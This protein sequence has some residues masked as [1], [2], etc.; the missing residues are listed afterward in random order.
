MVGGSA[1]K[2]GDADL[3]RAALPTGAGGGAL[4]LHGGVEAGLIEVNA[5]IARG[6]D[7]EVERKAEGV[8]EFEGFFA[9][10]RAVSP[11]DVEKIL[12]L[13]E[14]HGDGVGKAGLF[15]LDD[16]GYACGGFVSSG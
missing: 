15:A 3:L 12:Q 11:A 7:H 1:A 13:V 5:L 2:T 9:L 8:V 4:L 6:I 10:Q 14:P 16:L